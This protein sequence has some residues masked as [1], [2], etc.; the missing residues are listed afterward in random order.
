MGLDVSVFFLIHLLP[1]FIIVIDY[2]NNYSKIIY[3]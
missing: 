2:Y 1:L 3:T